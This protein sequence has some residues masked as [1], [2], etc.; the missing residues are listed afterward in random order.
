MNGLRSSR[1]SAMI[2]R[3][4]ADTGF[5]RTGNTDTELS[6]DANED[7]PSTCCTHGE[8]TALPTHRKISWP[9][10]KIYAP[11]S[12]KRAADSLGAWNT[13]CHIIMS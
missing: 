2:W 1:K 7:T 6:M 12:L 10:S 3:T 5:P 11:W 13:D 8:A 9:F 4:R